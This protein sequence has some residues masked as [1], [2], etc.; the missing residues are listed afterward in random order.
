MQRLLQGRMVRVHAQANNVDSLVR[1]SDGNFYAV[2]ET[3]AQILGIVPGQ[4]QATNFVMIRQ[5]PQFHTVS[6]RT[7]G[8]FRGAEHTI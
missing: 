7:R 6:M 8:E 2:H 3:Y 1:P 5:G 4:F